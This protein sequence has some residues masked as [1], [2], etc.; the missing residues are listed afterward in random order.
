MT[1]VLIF[2]NA[3]GSLVG[4]FIKNMKAHL[5]PTSK[6]LYIYSAVSIFWF[7][8]GWYFCP[9]YL[10]TGERFLAPPTDCSQKASR[11]TPR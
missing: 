8:Y 4:E 1:L 11:P 6:K 9:C 10:T 5:E 3:T 7:Q 2:F